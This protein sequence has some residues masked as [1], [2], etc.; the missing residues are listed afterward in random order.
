MIHG[1]S[2]ENLSS[3]FLPVCKLFKG[4]SRSLGYS[5][6][7]ESSKSHCFSI[8]SSEGGILPPYLPQYL[9]TPGVEHILTRQYCM[10][11]V[12]TWSVICFFLFHDCIQLSFTC[13]H[14]SNV[15]HHECNDVHCIGL[16]KTWFLSVTWQSYVR[17]SYPI[18]NQLINYCSKYE[19][20]ALEITLFQALPSASLKPQPMKCFHVEDRLS[21]GPSLCI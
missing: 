17:S 20:L 8:F 14:W 6:L 12:F 21:E 5:C 9:V 11:E 18:S 1:I 3:P 7:L 16:K 2:W 19:T 13:I 4:Q 10:P 15:D